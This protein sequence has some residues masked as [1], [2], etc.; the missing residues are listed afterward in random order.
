MGGACSVKGE[1]EKRTQDFGGETRGGK[2]LGRPR[3]RCEDNI[4]M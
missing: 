2:P 3:R 4:K 1:E